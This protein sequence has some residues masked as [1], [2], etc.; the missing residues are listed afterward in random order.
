MAPQ[1]ALNKIN[2]LI[3]NENN[4]GQLQ[5]DIQ[6][7]QVQLASAES[8]N[9]K[10]QALQHDFT[11]KLAKLR[12]DLSVFGPTLNLIKPTPIDPMKKAIAMQIQDVLAVLGFYDGV[13]DGNPQTTRAALIKYQE[14]KNDF[15][16]KGWFSPKV[17]N[18]MLIDY[19]NLVFNI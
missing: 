10:L 9:R 14:T 6:A 2:T 5:S 7:L 19:A 17:I 1:Q 12:R 8:S 18:H 11:V 3:Q 13:I 15:P 16:V 4:F